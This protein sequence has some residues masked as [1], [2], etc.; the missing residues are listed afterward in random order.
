MPGTPIAPTQHGRRCRPA[1]QSSSA[2]YLH[3]QKPAQMN[4]AAQREDVQERL[5]EY[6]RGIT[7]V[8]IP[9]TSQLSRL[10]GIAKGANAEGYRDRRDRH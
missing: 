7:G 2:S 6:L 8:A 9:P 4:P 3:H 10:Q 1:R 5:L